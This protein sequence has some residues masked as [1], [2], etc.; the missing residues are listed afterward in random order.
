M[1]GSSLSY[2]Y[3]KQDLLILFLSELNKNKLLMLL[4]S[5]DAILVVNATM[6]IKYFVLDTNLF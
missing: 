1:T 4:S 5:S 3:V 6:T 2:I